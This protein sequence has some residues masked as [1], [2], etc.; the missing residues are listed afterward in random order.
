MEYRVISI[1]DF[2]AAITIVI[3]GFWAL[4][5]FSR[6]NRI[7]AAE[8][9]LSAEKEYARHIEVLFSIENM[10]NYDREWRDA[11]RKAINGSPNLTRRQI[12]N[13]IKLEAALRH[14]FV[15][16]SLRSLGV[17][18]NSMGKLHA[19]YLNVLVTETCNGTLR[20]PEIREYIKLYWPGV[21]FWAEQNGL[22]FPKRFIKILG[23]IPLKLDIYWNGPKFYS[24]QTHNLRNR[25]ETDVFSNEDRDPTKL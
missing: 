8:L 13:F 11:L 12:K 18:V 22:P 9:L 20:R 15:S 16:N 17:D 14:L 5:C 3:G 21:Y 6:N 24:E 25:K 2:V 7:K 19:W 4:H 23:Q 10:T 1:Q